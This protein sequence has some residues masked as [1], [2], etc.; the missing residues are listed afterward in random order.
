MSDD[1]RFH[2]IEVA[3]ALLLIAISLSA[4]V[5]REVS[6]IRRRRKEKGRTPCGW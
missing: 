3:A 4:S 6:K 2:A 5:V 1:W